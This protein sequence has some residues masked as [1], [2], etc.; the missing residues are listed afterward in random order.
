MDLDEYL[1][2]LGLIA[3]REF[4]FDDT[5]NEEGRLQKINEW[6]QWW[7]EK[8]KQQKLDLNPLRERF[9]ARRQAFRSTVHLAD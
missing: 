7:E 5:M 9:E 2:L 6:K 8:G 3:G 1:S 4:F